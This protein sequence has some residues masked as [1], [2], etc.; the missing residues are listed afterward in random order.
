[1]K[2]LKKLKSFKK[3]Q[4]WKKG[5]GEML[6]FAIVAPII[7]FFIC[8][9]ASAAQIGITNQ[10]L[11]YAAYNC[12][13]AAAVSETEIIGNA[14]A[15]EVYGKSINISNSIQYGYTPCEIT[16]LDGEPWQKGSYIRC[17]ARYHIETLMPFTSGVREQSIVM[18]IE[19]GDLER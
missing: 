7:V 15:Y 12:C 14:R 18:M 1:M 8:V 4:F 11:S 13:R 10:N 16:L 9:I 17:T 2:N 3:K 19:N 6:G 5:N